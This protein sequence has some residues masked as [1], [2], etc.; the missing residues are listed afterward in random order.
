[1]L[2][3]FPTPAPSLTAVLHSTH[4]PTC[5]RADVPVKAKQPGGFQLDYRCSPRSVSKLA[6]SS[7]HTPPDGLSRRTGTRRLR[8]PCHT[9][10]SFPRMMPTYWSNTSRSKPRSLLSERSKLPGA[11]KQP[12][13]S[14]SSFVLIETLFPPSRT[15]NVFSLDPSSCSTSSL[16]V[17]MLSSTTLLPV[18]RST[19]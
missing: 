9:S 13:S 7:C 15:P 17:V 19:F 18:S 11:T 2:P 10:E 16:L 14:A 12:P 8:K 5:R 3:R 6:C 1:V 4:T